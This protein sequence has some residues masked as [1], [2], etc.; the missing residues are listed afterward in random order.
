MIIKNI[1]KEIE[2]EYDEKRNRAKQITE[3][4]KAYIYTNFPEIEQI[5]RTINILGI[6]TV[7]YVTKRKAPMSIVKGFPQA[8]LNFNKEEIDKYNIPDE[9]LEKITLFQEGLYWFKS[10][11]KQNVAE[12]KLP[13]DVKESFNKIFIF[14]SLI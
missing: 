7:Y 14:E 4:R 2:K 5:D 11:L 13:A 8:Y 12:T 6:L 1:Y 9:F 10:N 3:E